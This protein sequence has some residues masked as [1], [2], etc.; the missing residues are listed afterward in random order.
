MLHEQ[1][2]A[3]RAS[4]Q[5]AKLLHYNSLQEAESLSR[6]RV[7]GTLRRDL[8]VLGLREETLGSL[9]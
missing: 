5:E 3:A 2:Y 9:S 4:D 6:E 8:C 7:P 1:S